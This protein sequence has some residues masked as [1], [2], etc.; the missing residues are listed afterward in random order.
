MAPVAFGAEAEPAGLGGGAKIAAAALPSA[1]SPLATCPAQEVAAASLASGPPQRRVRRGGANPVAPAKG[2]V[3]FH[4]LLSSRPSSD[5]GEAA[6]VASAASSQ[7]TF[8][9]GVA[10]NQ[11]LAEENAALKRQLTALRHLLL[12]DVAAAEAA[13]AGRRR[14]RATAP[15][16][17]SPLTTTDSVLEMGGTGG[18]FELRMLPRL[19]AAQCA[20]QRTSRP[21]ST[22]VMDCSAGWSSRPPRQSGTPAL[23]CHG[24]QDFN[25]LGLVVAGYEDLPDCP[26][27]PSPTVSEYEELF[28]HYCPAAETPPTSAPGAQ[29]P[30]SGSGSGT[31]HNG[32]QTPGA[33]AGPRAA[34]ASAPTADPRQP[35]ERAPERTKILIPARPDDE[36][37]NIHQKR[38][39]G[40][41]GIQGACNVM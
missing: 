35:P 1:A 31:G 16:P 38:G 37:Q 10:I 32:K 21:S 9:E 41:C 28:R 2:R 18:E 36:E 3:P 5:A 26:R 27:L 14:R 8:K 39:A 40:A 34:A 20:G 11:E 25:A 7:F 4:G 23:D 30:A 6:P 29:S 19:Q 24:E 22:A 17:V 12:H 33:A 13:D 15:A